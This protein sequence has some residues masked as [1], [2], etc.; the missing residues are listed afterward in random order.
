MRRDL[1][2]RHRPV[3]RI[4][5]RIEPIGEQLDDARSAELP[6]RERNSMNDQQDHRR[7]FGA[8]VAVGRRYL[9]RR[10][11]DAGAVDKEAGPKRG[12]YAAVI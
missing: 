2:V 6:R 4:G 3:V 12:Q 11:H 8:I 1:D 5:G 10:A 9:R 7:A